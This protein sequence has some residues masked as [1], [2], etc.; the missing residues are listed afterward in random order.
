[1]SGSTSIS[2]SMVAW[3]SSSLGFLEAHEG[4]H[5]VLFPEHH[6]GQALHAAHVG[7]G[8]VL[9]ETSTDERS[10]KST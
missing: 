10:A 6:L 7:V 5:P 3:N 8:V 9:G 2:G 1:M 4:F